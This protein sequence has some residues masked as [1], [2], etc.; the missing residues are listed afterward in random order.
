MECVFNAKGVDGLETLHPKV[1][2]IEILI[3]VSLKLDSF[4]LWH[5]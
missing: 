3:N 5:C 2:S 1:P 4:T